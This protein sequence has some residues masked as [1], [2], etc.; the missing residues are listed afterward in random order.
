MPP[1]SAAKP[2]AQRI[3]LNYFK[4]PDR[5][6][7][8]K[9]VLAGT[10]FGLTLIWLL[11]G[12]SRGERS[13]NRYS[14]GEL[15][16]KHQQLDTNCAACHVDF[17][18]V[19]VQAWNAPLVSPF[20]RE[21][22]PVQILPADGKCQAC[23]PFTS[24]ADIHHGNQKLESLTSCGSCH[25]EHRGRN[26]ALSQ[27][28]D[29]D[30]TSCHRDLRANQTDRSIYEDRRKDSDQLANQITGFVKPEEGHPDFRALHQPDPGVIKFNHKVHL[31]PGIVYAE[32]ARPLTLGDIRAIDTEAFRRYED[33]QKEKGDKAPVTL[34]CGACH[35]PGDKGF[36]TWRPST[37]EAAYMEPIR[38]ERHCKVCHP[39]RFDDSLKP[40][41]ATVPHGLQPAEVERLV[42]GAY[43]ALGGTEPEPLRPPTVPL[44]GKPN[45]PPPALDTRVDLALKTLFVGKKTCGECHDYERQPADADGKRP[46]VPARILTSRPEDRSAKPWHSSPTAIPEVWFSHAR[47]NH[48]SH[49]FTSEGRKYEC[50]E[51]H[52]NAST[53]EDRKDKL[54][55]SI[56]KCRECHAPAA[57][58]DG[59]AVGGSR[60]DCSECHNFHHADEPATR[61]AVVKVPGGS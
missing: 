2:R 13:N 17:S 18:P 16:V 11:G 45:A 29:S 7:L 33:L 9:R 52:A 10:A 3:P 12:L 59:K 31:T 30:C 56:S 28:L 8:W 57:T 41:V 35:E 58:V 55:P 4:K 37:G 34:D 49:R 61:Q 51:C 15:A 36:K 14:H 48:K 40:D 60:Y 24:L 6:A 5:V 25:C 32:G 50:R 53:S 20:S 46:V 19:S 44:P 54:L 22:G 21:P 26:V 39:L 27:V 47:F 23:H 1:L 42:Q 38:Y 43:A